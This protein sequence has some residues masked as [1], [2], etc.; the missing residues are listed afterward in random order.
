M[1]NINRAR[2]EDMALSFEENFSGHEGQDSV[3]VRG[4]MHH[5]I[6]TTSQFEEWL[7]YEACERTRWT[8]SGG[9]PLETCLVK[10]RDG[11][12]RCTAMKLHADAFETV[13]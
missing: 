6:M 9:T 13:Y 11:S 2:I 3:I 8:H 7:V 10:R 1:T 12:V 4:S 5:A